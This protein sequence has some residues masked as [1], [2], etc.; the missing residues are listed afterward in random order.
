MK[1][2]INPLAPFFMVIPPLFDETVL[3]I[4]DVK[5]DYRIV[6]YDYEN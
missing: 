1:P 2:L 5:K 6:S 4:I 3:L